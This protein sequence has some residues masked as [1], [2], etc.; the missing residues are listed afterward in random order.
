MR[1]ATEP[2]SRVFELKFLVLHLFGPDLSS[3]IALESHMSTVINSVG[4]IPGANA[5]EGK[6]PLSFSLQAPQNDGRTLSSNGI[7]TNRPGSGIWWSHELYK[8]P[9]GKPVEVLYSRTKEQSEKIAQQFRNETVIGFDMEWPCMPW[10]LKGRTDLQSKVGL[11]Q[12]AT[13]DK[14]ALFHIGMH[15][16]KTTE[17]IIAPSL[18]YL[19]E[20]PTVGKVG[21]NV[22]KADLER[23]RK[24]FKLNPQGAVEISHL[25]RLAKYGR[26]RTQYA[27]TKLIALAT[28]TEEQLGYPLHKGDAR[29]S[30]W[31]RPLSKAQIK[32]A[33]ADA[34]AGIMLYHFLNHKR[35]QINPTPP[36]PI[37]HERYPGKRSGKEDP[38]LLDAGN[39][40]IVSVDSFFGF[41]RTDTTAADVNGTTG[42]TDDIRPTSKAVTSLDHVSLELYSRLVVRR[43]Q[44]AEQAKIQ[45]FRILSDKILQN[46]ALERPSTLR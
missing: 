11:I 5:N 35:L 46:I 43:A 28:L 31:S 10:H 34:Y 3:N 18:R 13:E 29:K 36:L 26:W 23:L 40:N 22:L 12:V 42:V 33:A 44:L 17:D 1:H 45:S 2:R 27:T 6:W 9:G 15:P 19:I 25:C 14:I 21:V 38:I 16:G 39:G 8:G 7:Q 32:Y 20:S 30:D 41:S 24:F 37:Y 4:S